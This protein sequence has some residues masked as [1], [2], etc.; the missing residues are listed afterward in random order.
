[1][2]KNE[3]LDN[4]KKVV[5]AEIITD[6][7]SEKPKSNK[8]LIISLSIIGVLLTAFTAVS[9]YNVL[10]LHDR[11]DG[12]SFR[13]N[14]SYSM[15]RDQQPSGERRGM[16]N[17]DRGQRMMYSDSNSII[18]TVIS[19]GTDSFVVAGSGKQY[20]VKTSTSTSVAVNDSVRVVGTL[21]GTTIT[22][23]SVQVINSL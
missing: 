12:V 22:A 3:N 21:S 1:M 6:V 19:V 14:E 20:T 8:P 5:D 11:P 9:A 7:K 18:G 13:T 10:F 4:D 17:S 15:N 16:M 23:S 2:N